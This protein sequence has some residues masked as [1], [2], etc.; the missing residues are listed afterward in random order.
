[1]KKLTI[2]LSHGRIW[3]VETSSGV[4]TQSST[5]AGAL[6]QIVPMNHADMAMQ[7]RP[8]ERYGFLPTILDAIP[9]SGGDGNIGRGVS[10]G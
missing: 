8:E 1:M 9:D 5:L 6:D 10:A 2:T 7:E 4:R 3:T